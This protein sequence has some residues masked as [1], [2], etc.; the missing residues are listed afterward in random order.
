MDYK[1]ISKVLDTS[2]ISKIKAGF[3]DADDEVDDLWIGDFAYN[4][5]SNWLNDPSES[6]NVY[7]ECE[8]KIIKR[9]FSALPPIVFSS[10]FIEALCQMIDL[11]YQD[12]FLPEALTIIYS[13]YIY[14]E[15]IELSPLVDIFNRIGSIFREAPDEIK[16]QILKL[17]SE[18]ALHSQETHNFI[19][20]LFPI[21]MIQELFLF[22]EDFSDSISYLIHG[23]SM[24]ENSPEQ[25][26][27]LLDISIQIFRN[28]FKIK[29][30]EWSIL[31][32]YTLTRSLY[33]IQNI[34][35]TM[36]PNF[37]NP[38]FELLYDNDIDKLINIVLQ[39]QSN[40]MVQ[41][42]KL[43]NFMYKNARILPSQNSFD[44]I[45]DI[46]NTKPKIPRI[47]YT[48][49]ISYLTNQENYD[50]IECLILSEKILSSQLS[51]ADDKTK[52]YEY[53]FK[54]NLLSHYQI[55]IE[56]GSFKLKIGT[57]TSLL[58]ILKFIP[59]YLMKQI[60]EIK[61]IFTLIN[62]IEADAPDLTVVLLQCINNILTNAIK[63]GFPVQDI[64]GYFNEKVGVDFD[65][66]N[67]EVQEEFSVFD[68]IRQ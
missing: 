42:M 19:I 21:Q 49:F 27:A 59:D 57:V 8:E 47:D 51:L 65:K 54:K 33:S 23:Y 68:M 61:M 48:I 37:T 66:E 25:S 38:S 45:D 52:I 35:I 12:S 16:D 15:E 55:L 39:N 56:N 24:N 10:D 6:Q 60:F 64:V 50:Q 18:A 31:H 22:N 53:I 2:K 62:E 34:C 5:A 7:F 17:L 44:I 11:Q 41:I 29:N 40:I 1:E 9:Q 36:S 58:D 3:C 13:F 14:D 30:N 26:L 32:R 46:E 20:S 43:V 63:F 28:S 4:F 67:V